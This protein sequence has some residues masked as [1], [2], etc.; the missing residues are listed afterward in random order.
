MIV[1]AAAVVRDGRVLAARRH[2]AP[3][4]W[5]FPGGKVEPGES[6][7][8]ALR[9]EIAEE[10]GVRI[11]VGV[12]LGESRTADGGVCLQLYRAA[13]RGPAPQRSTDHDRLAWWGPDELDGQDW[14]A[15]DR[16]LLPAVVAALAAPGMSG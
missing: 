13:L 5:E 8:Q 12:Q 2:R 16:P 11:D 7:P 10:L 1:V 9:R 6:G 15:L 4:G 14:L 3:V